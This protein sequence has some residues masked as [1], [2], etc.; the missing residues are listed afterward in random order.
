MS[1]DSNTYTERPSNVPW[2]PILIIGTVV[3]AVLL[4]I[5][6]PLPWPGL[7]DWPAQVVGVAFGVL[8][9]ALFLWAGYTL[10]RHD[11]TVMPHKGASRLVKDGPFARYRNPIYIADVL[12][13]LCVAEVTKNVWFVLLMPV[14]IG[15][16][17]WLAILPEERHLEAKFGDEYRAYK[18]QTRRWI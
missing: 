11:T 2:P 9:V 17:T 18:S 1:E 8:G 10:S 5:W 7:N 3:A 15:L 12:I 6:V 14:F 16:V 4:G 13:F